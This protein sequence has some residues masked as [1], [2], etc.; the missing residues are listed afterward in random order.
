MRK[1]RLSS[2]G[3]CLDD[4]TNYPEHEAGYA[5][6]DGDETGVIDR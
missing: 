6:D 3:Q 5:E 1:N 4:L 2:T